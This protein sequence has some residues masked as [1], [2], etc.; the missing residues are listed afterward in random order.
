MA[1]DRLDVRAP[2]VEQNVL[3]KQSP[4]RPYRLEA[5]SH[6][7]DEVPAYLATVGSNR[8]CERKRKK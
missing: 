2:L 5:P 7:I 4:N 8:D 6:R 1:H 3:V